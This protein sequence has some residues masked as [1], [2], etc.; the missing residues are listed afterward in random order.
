LLASG[1]PRSSA[2]KSAENS[3]AVDDDDPAAKAPAPADAVVKSSNSSSAGP[4]GPTVAGDENAP[5]EGAGSGRLGWDSGKDGWDSG[6]DE[7]NS[8]N[9]SLSLPQVSARVDS[10][11][12][13]EPNGESSAA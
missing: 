3:T 13:A 7:V 12:D 8:A 2:L 10:G 6:K 11:S 1:A 4:V 9:G 5:Q